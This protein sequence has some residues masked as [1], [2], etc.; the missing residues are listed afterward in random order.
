MDEKHIME[1]GKV[2]EFYSTFS[3]SGINVEVLTPLTK[4]EKA[5]FK[6]EIYSD[7]DVTSLRYVKDCRECMCD[8]TGKCAKHYMENICPNKDENMGRCILCGGIHEKED[9]EV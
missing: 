8:E 2:V 5:M 6:K 4:E 7:R 1:N 9:E 3:M